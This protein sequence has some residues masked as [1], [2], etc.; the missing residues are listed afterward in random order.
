MKGGTVTR[1]KLI[2]V[3]NGGGKFTISGRVTVNGV[4]LS[5]VLV[6]AN[7]LNPVVTDADGNYIVAN[8]SAN[9]Y[10][11]TPL[12]YGYSFSE[13]FSRFCRGEIRV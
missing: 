3:G 2:T 8:L 12:L 10:S 9:T 5:G 6:N 13:Q 1:T 7:G 11:V 4:G